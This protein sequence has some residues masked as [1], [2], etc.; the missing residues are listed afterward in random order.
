MIENILDVAMLV[1]FG[2]YYDVKGV[3][4]LQVLKRVRYRLVLVNSSRNATSPTPNGDGVAHPQC[5][6]QACS[7]YFHHPSPQK[8]CLPSH[9]ICGGV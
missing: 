4:G 1:V 2:G 9:T 3:A 8:L 7:V 6:H 5:R